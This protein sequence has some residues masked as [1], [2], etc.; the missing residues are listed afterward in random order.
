VPSILI[1][2]YLLDARQ[3]ARCQGLYGLS[4]VILIISYNLFMDSLKLLE[5]L[6]E[7]LKTHP[8][9]LGTAKSIAKFYQKLNPAINHATNYFIKMYQDKNRNLFYKELAQ[10]NTQNKD[11]MEIGTGL[12]LI[13]YYILQTKPSYFMTCELNRHSFLKAEEFF[14]TNNLLD[15]L[16]LLNKSSFEIFYPEDTEKKFDFIIHELF[17]SNPFAEGFLPIIM[18]AKRLLKTQGKF[19]P[20]IF[21][22]K[23]I[24]V[25]YINHQFDGV[26]NELKQLNLDCYNNYYENQLI[27]LDQNIEITTKANSI[28]VFEIDLNS[29]FK[30]NDQFILKKDTLAGFDGLIVY[31]QAI[32]GDMIL[33]NYNDE[34]SNYI[35]DHWGSSIFVLNNKHLKNIEFQY[36]RTKLEIKPL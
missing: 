21:K 4:G 10:K 20:G 30:L 35:C 28:T 34:D 13:A 17:A 27:S 16:V 36:D 25:N 8:D 24:P 6:E 7:K 22:L 14:K 19:L 5:S 15:K 31:F 2:Y 9:D 26:K 32:E 11:V 18:N 1:K 3:G 29:D 23:A 33:S 12:G